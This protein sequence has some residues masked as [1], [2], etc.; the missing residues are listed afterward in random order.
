MKFQHHTKN[1]IH[2]D[3]T[4]K[5]IECFYVVYRSLGYGFLEKVYENALMKELQLH[6]LHAEKQKEIKVIYKGIIAGDY[7]AVIV[8]ANKVIIEINAAE[9]LAEEH[10]AQLINYLKATHLE[11]ELLLNFDKEPQVRRKVFSNDRKKLLKS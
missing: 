9:T 10:E 5:I 3:I 11:V 4:D 2:S 1:Y 6:S 7:Y 8:V